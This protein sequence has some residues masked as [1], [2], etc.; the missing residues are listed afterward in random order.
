MEFDFDREINEIWNGTIEEHE[1]NHYVVRNAE[2][3]STIAPGESVSIGIKGCDGESGDEPINYVLYSY[4]V[5]Q[6]E[7][8]D[9]TDSDND[10]LPDFYEEAI[11]TDKYNTDSDNDG[12]PDGFELFTTLTYPN[13]PDTDNDGIL[14]GQEDNDNDGISNLEE[15]EMV[16]DP[17]DADTDGDGLSDS[18][19]LKYNMN[20]NDRDSLDDGILD[21]NRE[22]SITV[23]CEASDNGLAVPNLDI[24]LTG[25]QIDSLSTIKL[26]DD[27]PFLNSDIPGY[28][29]NGYEFLLDGTFVSAKLSFS[30]DESVLNDSSIEPRIYYWNET[31]QLFEEVENQYMDGNNLCVPLSHF[32]KYIVL[33]KREYNNYA[34]QFVI[35]APS[36]AEELT[37]KFDIAFVLDDSGSISSSDFTKMRDECKQLSDRFTENDRLALFMFASSVSKLTSFTDKDTFAECLSSY[38]RTNG[39]TALYSGINS[40]TTEFK[41]YSTDA[42]RI[43]I[44]VTDGYNNQSGASSATVINNAI[45]EN[46]IIYCVGVG[47]VNSTV[48]KKISES[49]GGCYYYINQFSQLNGIF[50]NIISETDL[51]KD[52]DGDGLSDYHEKMIAAGKMHTGSGEALRLCT[53]MNYLSSDSDGDGLADSE[54]VEIRKIP[55]S[56]NYYCYMV[57]NPCVVDTDCDSY[58]DYVEEYIGSSPVSKINKI[59]QTESSTSGYSVKWSDWQELIEEHAWNYIHN[60]VEADIYS[61]NVGIQLETPISVGRIDVLRLATN[62]VWDVKPPS[63]VYEPNRSKGIAQVSRYV[64]AIGGKIGGLYIKPELFTE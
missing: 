55:N 3:N 54:E 53:T 29:S 34:F 13:S 35:E 60:A 26:E 1:D 42:S 9:L 20:P 24:T 28:L 37:T 50:E 27:D 56:E 10:G 21:G 32:S 25:N 2:Y 58:N 64:N 15:F 5:A 4:S 31:T 22:F 33:N 49:T 36:T 45:E 63:Y 7:E 46:V 44:V 30:L 17:N 59:E 11:G 14:D 43:M 8:V 12:L 16:I 6:N 39:M 40:A 41:N 52:S 51:Y 19:E 38:R 47:S 18:N 62:E 48:L 61:K 23:A 57:S